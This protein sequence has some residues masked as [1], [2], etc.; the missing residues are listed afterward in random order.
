MVTYLSSKESLTMSGNA[1][2][3]WI[4]LIGFVVPFLTLAGSAA[5]YVVKLYQD[6]DERRHKRFFEL[7]TH[8]DGQGT[9]AA[10]VGAIYALREF[11]EHREFIERFCENQ[12]TNISGPAAPILIAELDK[13]KEAMRDLARP[14]LS[15]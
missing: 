1:V 2:P 4:T 9:I 3:L 10:K 15:G 6:A 12:R 11:K 5:A 14:V 8:I 13:T 7:L